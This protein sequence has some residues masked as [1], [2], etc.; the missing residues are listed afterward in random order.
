VN[1]SSARGYF[2]HL[3]GKVDILPSKYIQ[4]VQNRQSISCS[5]AELNSLSDRAVESITQALSI[6]NELVQSLLEVIRQDIDYL[7]GLIDS[8]VSNIPHLLADSN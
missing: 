4:A 3:Q 5:T 8:V 7:F 2:F 1:Y 6:T